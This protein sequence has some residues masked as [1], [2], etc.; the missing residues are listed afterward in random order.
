MGTKDYRCLNVSSGEIGLLDEALRR[1]E[2]FIANQTELEKVRAHR[3]HRPDVR[4]RWEDWQTTMEERKK[5]IGS[6][7]DRLSELTADATEAP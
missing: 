7:R 1:F 4:I 2:E 5:I 3:A 6:L